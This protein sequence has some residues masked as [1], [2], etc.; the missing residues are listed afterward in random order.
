MAQAPGAHSLPNHS[1]VRLVLQLCHCRAPSQPYCL[2]IWLVSFNTALYV[3]VCHS[4]V[5]PFC[6]PF[7]D[8][9]LP[10][11]EDVP[12]TPLVLKQLPRLVVA[13]IGV[14]LCYVLSDY[15]SL[16]MYCSLYMVPCVAIE[17][18]GFQNKILYCLTTGNI[19]SW[20]C[21]DDPDCTSNS[22]YELDAWYLVRKMRPSNI[23]LGITLKGRYKTACN[24]H[25]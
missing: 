13:D 11:L 19:I 10:H 23:A 4:H 22:P 16:P 24:A 5:T 7:F 17:P 25:Y 12:L 15:S 2:S 14:C 18:C 1:C 8:A 3:P 6:C 9:F 20:E 21:C